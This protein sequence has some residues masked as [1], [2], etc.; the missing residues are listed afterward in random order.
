MPIHHVAHVDWSFA[1]TPGPS[2]ATS[3][4]LSRQVIVGPAQGAVHTELAV[5]AFAAGG[6]LGRHVHSYEEALYVLGGFGLTAAV[7]IPLNNAL[8]RVRPADAAQ[9][10]E[11]FHRRWALANHTRGLACAAASV[12]LAVA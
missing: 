7:N 12:V 3:S 2:G 9:G 10:W 4:G 1:A 11:R 5:G 8:D 6:W